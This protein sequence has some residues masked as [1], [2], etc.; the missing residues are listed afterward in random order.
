MVKFLIRLLAG[1]LILANGTAFGQDTSAASEGSASELL[2]SSDVFSTQLDRSFDHERWNTLIGLWN[3]TLQEPE[4]YAEFGRFDRTRSDAYLKAAGDTLKEARSA[5]QE[6]AEEKRALN[7]LLDA[8]GPLPAEGEPPESDSIT[9][10]RARYRQ[11]LAEIRSTEALVGLVIQRAEIVMENL[12]RLQR[13]TLIEDLKHRSQIYTTEQLKSLLPTI[14]R[15]LQFVFLI[16][17]DWHATLS[18]E[19]RR[20]LRVTRTIFAFVL[21]GLL[22]WIIGSRLNRRF[23]RDPTVT[24]P[25]WSRRLVAAISEGLTRGIIPAAVAGVPLLLLSGVFPNATLYQLLNGTAAGQ[26]LWGLFSSLVGL[27]L[28]IALLNALLSP[29]LPNWRLTRASGARAA[30]VVRRVIFLLVIIGVESIARTVHTVA[31]GSIG[32]GASLSGAAVSAE[33]PGLHQMIYLVLEGIAILS[34][35]QRRLWSEE[36]PDEEETQAPHTLWR[37]VRYGVIGLT[38]IAVGAALVGYLGLS[39]YLIHSIIFSGIVLTVGIVIRNLMF[40]LISLSAQHSF[41]RKR[42]GVRILTLQRLK[43]VERIVVDVLIVYFIVVAILSIWGVPNAELARWSHRLIT[44]IQVGGITI[45]IADVILAIAMFL[46]GLAATRLLQRKL[47]ND[48]LP[49]TRLASGAQYSVSKIIGYVGVFVAAVLAIS[50]VGIDLSKIALIAGALSLGIGFGLQNAVD[51]FVS[52]IILLT[53]RPVKVGDWI[54]IGENEGYVKKINVRSTELETFTRATVII[55]NSELI[56]SPVMNMT[57]EDRFGRVE[58][59]VGVAYGSDIDLVEKTLLSAAIE[60]EEILDEPPPHVLFRNFGESS[61]DFE[62][63]GFTNNVEY[64]LKISS[65]IRFRIDREFKALGIEIPFPQRVV[66][67][68]DSRGPALSG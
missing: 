16:P 49:K 56:S 14:V 66:H 11:D 7:R 3:L 18:P 22:A 4:Q 68:P 32:L 50:V 10:K 30:S 43:T 39:R 29:R 19:N 6:L 67:L 42:F 21:A 55:P 51:N 58:V 27:I 63:R 59:A 9:A 17:L 28:A 52:G 13:A 1:L 60:H 54:Q 25:S 36:T 45:S 24:D 37:L 46:I 5:R 62:L 44:E 15:N 57:H 8:L 35:C 64:R 48:L 38:L 47:L 40:E 34:L 12:S 33:L 41:L 31:A 23:G 65:D 20:Q 26:L 53:E 2:R 61:L